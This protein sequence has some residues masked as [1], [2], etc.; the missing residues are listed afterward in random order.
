MTL[1]PWSTASTMPIPEA[2]EALRTNERIL[3]IVTDDSGRPQGIVTMKDLV[4][5]LTGELEALTMDPFSVEK[6]SKT[7]PRVVPAP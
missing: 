6:I 7:T 3:A 1:A 2:L 5:V 4:E